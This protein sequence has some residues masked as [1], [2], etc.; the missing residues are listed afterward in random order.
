MAVLF[1]A[2]NPAALHTLLSTR[3]AAGALAE[4]AA[5][6]GVGKIEG[7]AYSGFR[8]PDRKICSYVARLG[9]VVVVTNS[10][11]Q[12]EQLVKAHEERTPTL[13]SLA[14][15]KFF[16]T[17]YPRAAAEESAF[18]FLSDA[19]IRRW[20]GPRWRIRVMKTAATIR[21]RAQSHSVKRLVAT[22]IEELLEIMPELREV[23][24]WNTVGQ[25][26]TQDELGQV[27]DRQLPDDFYKRRTR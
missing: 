18:L 8:S 11:A 24:G 10:L 6:P 4:P 23:V 1:E 16:R 20:C 13:A 7:T 22:L 14:E 25:R 3:V 26:R 19:T 17:R 5:K 15:F 9:E 21:E 2:A 27:V 12:L